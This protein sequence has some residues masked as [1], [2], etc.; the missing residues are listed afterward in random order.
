MPSPV[1][2]PSGVTN[3][4]SGNPL[5]QYGLPDPTKWHTYFNDFDRF[6]T[7]ITTEWTETVIGTGT[8]A[9]TAVDGGCLLLTNSAADNDGVQIQRVP[10]S[11]TLTAGKRAIFKA[12]FKVSD[13]TQSDLLIG[14]A[15]ADTTLLGATAGAG[16]TDGIFFSKDDGA[17]TL[18]VSCQK[19]ATTG[20]TIASA[21][22]TLVNNTF[23]TVA[24]Y[25]DGVD[26]V[27]YYVNDV[28]LGTLDG[29][30]TYLPDTILTDSIALLNGEAVAKNMTIDYL[31]TALER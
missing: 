10:A 22:A 25:Y 23:V 9:A 6:T 4:T 24:W 18:N 11:Y 20:Q 17:A 13:V 26:K 5:G 7:G 1:R 28:Q 21:I 15:V 31:F 19:N 12:R 3:V 2:Y 8:A 30:S 29:S 16:V 27:G 14:I